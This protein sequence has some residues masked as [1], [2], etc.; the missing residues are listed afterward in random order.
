MF[1]IALCLMMPCESSSIC[2]PFFPATLRFLLSI[3]LPSLRIE[4]TK[5]L[6]NQVISTRR[7][8]TVTLH[9]VERGAPPIGQDSARTS[10]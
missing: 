1:G 10:S 5:T 7:K 6:F 8:E 2:L 4:L 3:L 9:E